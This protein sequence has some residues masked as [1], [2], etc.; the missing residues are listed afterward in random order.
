MGLH[1][2]VNVF[3]SRPDAAAN[4]RDFRVDEARTQRGGEVMK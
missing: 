4:N 1:G 3:R 2:E